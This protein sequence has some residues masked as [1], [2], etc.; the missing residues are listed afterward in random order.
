MALAEK[1]RVEKPRI[2]KLRVVLFSFGFK[3]GTPVG[4]NLV[5]DVRFL[6][7]PYWQDHLR[8]KTGLVE[9]VADYVLESEEGIAFLEQLKPMLKF[10]VEK[11]IAAGKR[12]LNI[13]IGCTG[14]CHRSVAVTEA[15]AQYMMDLSV[16]L[17]VFH[18]DIERD[19]DP[20]LL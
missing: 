17:S 8:P 16:D 14:G 9:E 6:P 7:N 1:L 3:Y 12:S 4:V 11:N 2:E 13:G 10:L 20:G 18:R 15:I 5:W 19:G